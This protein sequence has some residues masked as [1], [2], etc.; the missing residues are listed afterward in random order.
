MHIFC[1]NCLKEYS[2]GIIQSGQIQ[3]LKCPSLQNKSECKTHIREKD[4]EILDISEQFMEKYTKLLISR[5]IDGMED[6]GFCPQCQA[7]A[8]IEKIKNS[9]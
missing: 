1:K 6:Y 4:L 5:A 9:G 3:K 2:I 7:P 8:E